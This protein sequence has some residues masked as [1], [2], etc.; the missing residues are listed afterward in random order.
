MENKNTRLIINSLPKSGTHLLA[1]AVDIFGYK[2]HFDERDIDNS[3]RV[4]PLFFNYK[5][6]KNTL[7]KEGKLAQEGNASIAIGTLTPIHVDVKTFQNWLEGVSR[8]RY[9]LG[10]I[11]W[12]P[13]LSCLLAELN[14]RH[15]FIIRDPRAVIVSLLSFIQNT[16]AMPKK[17]FLE[18]DF[19]Q[20]TAKQRLQL[21]LEG[22]YAFHSGVQVTAFR[23]IFRSMLAW[24]RETGC[25]FVRFEDLVGVQGGG[26]DERQ[27][28]AV[29]RIAEHLGSEF[30]ERIAVE[31]R[32][33]YS[34][35][36]RTFRKGNIDGWKASL[37]IESIEQVNEYCQSLCQEAGY[38]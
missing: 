32:Q 12:S 11:A 21:I 6:T 28:D 4:T 1:N 9:I 36:A 26:S 29:K 10:H 31:V 20:M 14:Y 19:I 8:G 33:I 5:E 13:T 35:S 18:A 24:R 25:L 23:D 22:G 15:L 2:E 34:P 27:T 30:D 37:D 16:G 3:G 7:A 38:L 17:H